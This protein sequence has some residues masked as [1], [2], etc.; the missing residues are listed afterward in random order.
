M[1]G[2]RGGGGARVTGGRGQR[3]SNEY[4]HMIHNYTQTQ[5]VMTHESQ[6]M[7]E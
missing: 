2:G 3:P 7:A 4:V 6:L 1:Q 5:S